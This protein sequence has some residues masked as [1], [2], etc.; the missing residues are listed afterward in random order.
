VELVR[1]VRALL[2]RCGGRVTLLPIPRL[3]DTDARERVAL[4]CIFCV[5][6]CIFFQVRHG[7]RAIN[8]GAFGL[9]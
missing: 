5:C 3:F 2:Q 7:Q 6:T 8:P 4:S 9:V 1:C